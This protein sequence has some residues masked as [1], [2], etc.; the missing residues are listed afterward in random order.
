MLPGLVGHDPWKQD[1]AYVFGGVLDMLQDGDWVLV[2]V[3]GIPF[4][5]KPPLYHWVAALCARLFSGWLPLHDGARL[6]SGL[7]VAAGLGGV[8]IASRLLWGSGNGR[9]GALMSLSALGLVTNAQL[10][11]TDLPL[12]AG[13][14]I[15]LAGLAGCSA[16]RPW[17][18]FVLGIG[19]GVGFLGKGI[20]APAVLGLSAAVL[21][22]LFPPW[23][24]RRYL[25][26]ICLSIAVALPF[27]IVWPLALWNHSHG[28]FMSWFWDNNIGRYLGFSV[29]SL[30]AATE[31]GY[32]LKTWPWFLFPLWVYVAL[33]LLRDGR[34]LLERPAAQI[35]LT[36]AGCIALVLTSAASAR[37]IYAL[38]MIPALALVATGSVRATPQFS[39]A[40]SVAG[41][42]IA[43]ITGIVVWYGWALLA[44]ASRAP[45]LPWLTAYFQ[46]RFALE[47]DVDDVLFATILSLGFVAIAFRLR[48]SSM[49]GITIW[50]GSLATAWGL[51]ASLWLPWIDNSKSYRGMYESLS[52][53]IPPNIDCVAT[54]GLGE[55]ER[56]VL[57]YV[58]GIPTIDP[59]NGCAAVLTQ[60][61]TAKMAAPNPESWRLLWSGSRPGDYRER[62]ELWLRNAG[63]G[64]TG[65][66]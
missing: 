41:I 21:P 63:A 4:M 3:G 47:L 8:A 30:G 49:G 64:D 59:S 10:M 2:K 42:G 16:R 51:V 31:S 32:W 56:A 50:V 7:F 33:A 46:P 54:R 23:R 37:S 57:E 18:G 24:T 6:A 19:V 20:F 53:A 39:R 45:E 22:V 48:N 1:E 29:P 44:F 58:L 5:E 55:S 14:A 62:F 61:T 66:L 27:L 35:G 52:H 38:P 60:R 34:R 11:L 40:L 13:F 26:D 17:G 65:R 12:M 15:A 25:R 28:L 36:V 43:T 9:I